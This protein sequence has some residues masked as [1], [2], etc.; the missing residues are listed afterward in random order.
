M[1]RMSDGNEEPSP[2]A[3]KSLVGL[4]AKTLDLKP[5]RLVSPKTKKKTKGLKSLY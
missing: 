4:K 1:S 5:T 2:Q 3:E